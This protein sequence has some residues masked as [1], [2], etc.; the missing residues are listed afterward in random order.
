MFPYYISSSPLVVSSL[1]LAIVGCSA[2]KDSESSDAV[3]SAFLTSANLSPDK[4]KYETVDS[5][6]VKKEFEGGESK[7]YANA[8]KNADE[9]ASE[10]CYIEKLNTFKVTAKG[11]RISLG[12]MADMADCFKTAFSKVF[13]TYSVTAEVKLFVEQTCKD[14]DL[15]SFDG[16]TF[17]EIAKNNELE[18]PSATSATELSNTALSIIFSGTVKGQ[19]L[20]M[21]FDILIATMT[22]DGKPCESTRTADTIIMTDGCLSVSLNTNKKYRVNGDVH[23]SEGKQKYQKLEFSSIIEKDDKTSL[24]YS[25]GVIK[26]TLNDWM[27]NVTYT[28]AD[29]EPSYSVTNGADTITG[30]VPETRS[31]LAFNLSQARQQLGDIIKQAVAR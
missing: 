20:E 14:I 5:D 16:K 10:V 29:V 18:C 31:T 13:E 6:D 26:F 11:D 8:P 25:S 2:K 9:D 19:K 3:T 23:A 28:A 27:G 22:A 17:S 12:G 24:F 21:D 30:K 15:T 1:V 7:L 4:T